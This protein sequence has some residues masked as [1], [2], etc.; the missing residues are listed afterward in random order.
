MPVSSALPSVK[1]FSAA[2]RR[3]EKKA[4]AQRRIAT[5]LIGRPK[6]ILDLLVGAAFLLLSLPVM[7][8]VA[9]M[10]IIIDGHPVIFMQERLGWKGRR[11]RMPKFRTLRCDVP[12]DRFL[13]PE[14]RESAATC[15]GMWLRRYRLDELPQ[16]F[17][18][19]WGDMSLVGPRPEI[20]A[21]AAD[22]S[23]VHASRLLVR[24]GLTGL[25]QVKATRDKPI[26][27][28]FEYDLHYME[29]ASI[30]MD[31]RIL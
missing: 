31:G 8:A 28:N 11:F 2:G 21:I 5:Y 25:W 15:L 19:V 1:A 20:S 29:N 9:V 13:S 4:V 12:A 17:L 18:V 27:E 6:R 3:V 22:W 7:A 30:W 26:H 16:L 24:P 10:I 23:G 14:E